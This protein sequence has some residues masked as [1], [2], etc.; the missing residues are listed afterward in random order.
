MIIIPAIDIKGGKCVSLIQG[1]AAKQTIYSDSPSDIAKEFNEK[2]AKLIHVVDLDGAFEGE[3]INLRV[4]EEIANN[5]DCPIEIGGGIRN[6]SHIDNLINVGVSRCII[7]T[8]AIKDPDFLKEAVIKYGDRIL[9]SIDA[10]NGMVAIK[11]WVEESS[12]KALDLAL[13][14]KQQDIKEIVYTDISRD[15]MLT[16]PNLNE[17][18]YIAE[19]SG[20]RVIASGGVSNIDDV[21]NLL[22]MEPLGIIGI[23]IGKA[24]YE[25]TIDLSEALELVGGK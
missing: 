5:V 10:N 1:K 17:L 9:V 6:M 25:K 24:L 23:I 16:G 21:R 11:G 15:G 22:N 20:L 4:I 13:Q 8:A 19:N 3:Q 14:V 12:T 2:G 18:K 7:G